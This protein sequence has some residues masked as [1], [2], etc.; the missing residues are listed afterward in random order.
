MLHASKGAFKTFPR[1]ASRFKHNIE[2]RPVFKPTRLRGERWLQHFDIGPH[3]CRFGQVVWSSVRRRALSGS[4]ISLR[5][6]AHALRRGPN[7]FPRGEFWRPTGRTSASALR[8]PPR[9]L[10]HRWA[11]AGSSVGPRAP[12]AAAWRRRRPSSAS[13]ALSWGSAS[14]AASSSARAG[15]SVGARRLARALAR[16]RDTRRW[17]SVFVP[18][19]RLRPEPDVCASA[20]PQAR[21]RQ[22]R[23]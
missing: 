8:P 5:A 23:S 10:G 7:T 9:P 4:E 6:P 14:H 13:R 18:T 19:S 11:L 17:R 22:H 16:H 20:R 1:K 2:C 15:R 3:I 12:A 21:Q